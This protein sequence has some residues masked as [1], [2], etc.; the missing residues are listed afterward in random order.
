MFGQTP[1]QMADAMKGSDLLD[2]V[3]EADS[4]LNN[5]APAAPESKPAE[6]APAAK[7]EPEKTEQEAVETL[8]PIDKPEDVKAPEPEVKAPEVKEPEVKKVVEETKAPEVVKTFEQM[9][10][11]KKS[12]F[13]S[14]DEMQETIEALRANQGDKFH[15]EEMKKLNALKA[16][17][18]K[19]D[20]QFWAMQSK[21][22]EGMKDPESILIEHMKHLDGYGDYTDKQL[23][24]EINDKYNKSEWLDEDDVLTDKGELMQLRLRRDSDRAKIELIA[25]KEELTIIAKPDPLAAEQQRVA[26]VQKQ[27][28]WDQYVDSAFTDQTPKLTIVVDNKTNETFDFEVSDSDRAEATE[29][30]KGFNT[31]TDLFF[32]Q[33]KNEDGVIDNKEVYEFIIYYKNKDKIM[34]FAAQNAKAKGA[35]AEV[36]DLKNTNFNTSGGEQQKIEKNTDADAIRGSGIF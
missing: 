8:K 31:G 25:K 36:K 30:M 27:E 22:F 20:D 23:L 5:T 21:D 26:E 3:P 28:N 29:I 13:K 19:L 10:E 14:L 18:V 32:D 33:F 12:G 2:K 15:D 1:E 35:E 9:F 4:S 16:S 7:V 34:Q 11:D 17:G 6:T 24:A